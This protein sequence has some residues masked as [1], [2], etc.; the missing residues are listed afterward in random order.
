MISFTVGFITGG[1][2][3]FFIT[4]LVVAAGQNKRGDGDDNCRR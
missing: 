2:T 4:C 3:G 1:I